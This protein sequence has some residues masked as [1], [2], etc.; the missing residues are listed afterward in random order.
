MIEVNHTVRFP[1][2]KEEFYSVL[3]D[4]KNYSD[5]FD[6]VDSVEIISQNGNTIVAKLQ[7]SWIKKVSYTLELTLNPGK[8]VSWKLAE[9]SKVLSKNEGVWELSEDDEGLLVSYSLSLDF[10]GKV[11]DVIVKK[12]TAIQLPLMVESIYKKALNPGV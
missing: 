9:K 6:G 11:P 5:V 2:S 8:S 3:A 12:L 7:L 4:V 1:I 10:F